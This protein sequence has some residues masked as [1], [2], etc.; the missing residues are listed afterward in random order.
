MSYDGMLPKKYNKNKLGY[1]PVTSYE[2]WEELP[3]VYKAMEWFPIEVYDRFL[4]RKEKTVAEYIEFDV[5]YMKPYKIRATVKVHVQEIQKIL[6]CL[7]KDHDC[8]LYSISGVVF[9]NGERW[10]AKWVQDRTTG[11]YAIVS[12]GHYIGMQGGYMGFIPNQIERTEDGF[13]WKGCGNRGNRCHYE[14][15]N[16]FDR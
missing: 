11:A 6:F 12:C 13:K 14:V 16:P 10:G 4:K 1:Y 2:E 9:A 8:H 5:T 3:K 15:M 7:Y